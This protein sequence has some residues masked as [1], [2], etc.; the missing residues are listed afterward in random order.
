MYLSSLKDESKQE[1]FVTKCN[2]RPRCK[3][4]WYST[5]LSFGNFPGRDFIRSRMA[6]RIIKG[7]P[8]KSLSEKYF[9]FVNDLFAIFFL[10]CKRGADGH[11]FLFR[12][13][14]AVLNVYFNRQVGYVYYNDI[15]FKVEDFICTSSSFML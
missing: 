1:S 10:N 7:N 14:V 5:E 13:N 8:S 6:D 11:L 9:R 2:C 4:H 3:E 15:P 12:N